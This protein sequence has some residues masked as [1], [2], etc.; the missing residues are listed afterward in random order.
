MDTDLWD[1]LSQLE[2]PPVPA[3]F[4]SRLHERLNRTLLWLHASDFVLR[5]APRALGQ[6]LAAW[7]G[8]AAYTL[9]G[10]FPAPRSTDSQ[11][12]RPA[13]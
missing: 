13:G 9:T 12:D 4:S 7:L 8:L 11:N 1:D 3:N 5:A 10:R 2:V 6:F